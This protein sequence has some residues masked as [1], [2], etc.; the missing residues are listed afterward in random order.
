MYRFASL[1]TAY[2]SAIQLTLEVEQA[3]TCVNNAET[4]C[5]NWPAA[6]MPTT[7]PDT[8]LNAS[9]FTHDT[10]LIWLHGAGGVPSYYQGIFDVA[11][12]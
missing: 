1:L 2:A 6:M 5:A 3:S 8:P 11:L 9:D 4:K 10:V 12:P 7:N